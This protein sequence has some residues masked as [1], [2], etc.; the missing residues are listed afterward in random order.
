MPCRYVIDKERRL[1]IS[2]AWDRVTFEEMKA[3]DDQ[4]RNDPEFAPEFDQLADGT[5]VTVVEGAIDQVRTLAGRSPFAATS[6]RAFVANSPSV[7][8]ME[9]LMTTHIEMSKTPSHVGVFR[10]VPSALEWLG[11]EVLPEA[12]KPQDAKKAPAGTTRNDRTA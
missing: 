8:G 3:H 2:T 11:L 1:V 7:Y 12:I 6:R 9:R 5:R 10:D 4:L